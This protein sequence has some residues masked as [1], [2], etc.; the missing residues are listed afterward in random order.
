MISSLHCDRSDIGHTTRVVLLPKIVTQQTAIRWGRCHNFQRGG[1]K[2]HW[3]QMKDF[4]AE[5]RASR[6]FSPFPSRLL[7]YHPLQ[8]RSPACKR[9][10]KVNTTGACVQGIVEYCYLLAG[11]AERSGG[12][13]DSLRN[14]APL[15]AP[16]HRRPL[17]Q[18]PRHS[19]ALSFHSPHH[20][21]PARP[22]QRTCVDTQ[23]TRCFGLQLLFLARGARGE[24]R[25]GYYSSH[26]GCLCLVFASPLSSP[27]VSLLDIQYS[28]CF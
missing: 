1:K 19:P 15:P 24:R 9:E 13:T 6:S 26:K 20:L 8:T 11:S 10:R 17:L 14:G 27:R 7:K 23:Q 12:R 5:E 2:S 16:S 21:L 3:D 4:L 25:I 28:A 22:R 18:L